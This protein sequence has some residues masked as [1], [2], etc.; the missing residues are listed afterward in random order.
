MSPPPSRPPLLIVFPAM[1]MGVQFQFIYIYYNNNIGNILLKK[2][3][4]SVENGRQPCCCRCC[5]IQLGK[6][7]ATVVGEGDRGRG[8]VAGRYVRRRI[9]KGD[10]AACGGGREIEERRSGE[11]ERAV[12]G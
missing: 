2:D 1:D 8:V 9:E 10:V 7:E 6:K 4:D 3:S 12:D 11:R 5:A